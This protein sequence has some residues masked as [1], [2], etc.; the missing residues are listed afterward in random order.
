VERENESGKAK[1]IINDHR[2]L[3]GQVNQRKPENLGVQNK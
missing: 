2:N 3:K 1:K